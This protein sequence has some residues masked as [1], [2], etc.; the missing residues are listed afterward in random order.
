MKSPDGHSMSGK[1]VYREI[2]APERMVFIVSFSD[3]MGGTTRHPMSQTW[4]LEVL[5]ILTL[6]EHEGKTTLTLRG[7]PINATEE[8]RKTFEE[9]FK[10]MQQ[11]FTGTFDQ[12]EEYLS[13]I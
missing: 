2:V 9:N 11:G 12:F 3:E 8:E 7:G 5:N 13:K 10:G 6:T 4:P 1:F